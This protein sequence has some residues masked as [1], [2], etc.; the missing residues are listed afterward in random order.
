MKQPLSAKFKRHRASRSRERLSELLDRLAR[1][2]DS[3]RMV[4][5]SLQE[6]VGDRTFGALILVF[7]IPALVVGIVPGI[8]T[9]L[10]LPLVLL[11]LQLMI[12][13]PRPWFPRS[14]SARSMERS[15]FARM[16]ASV[17]PRLQRFEKL[18]KLR[19]LP[20]T[21]TWAD[22]II[23][24]CCLVAAALVF[25]PIPFGNL[26]PAMALC[27]F[28]LALMERDGVL[29]LAGLGWIGEP[30]FARLLEPVLGYFGVTDPKLLHSIAF[31]VAFTFISFLHIVLGEL[32]PKSIAIRCAETVALNTALPLYVFY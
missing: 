17:R 27:A 1:E 24:L 16:V 15:A 25:L 6:A 13:S 26:L 29:V 19:L 31:A 3:E 21:S 10:G 4:F 5:G 32:A 30:A 7:A 9:L 22:R 18:L 11:S 23:G 8:S 2:G 14:V 12:G 20:L 28:G